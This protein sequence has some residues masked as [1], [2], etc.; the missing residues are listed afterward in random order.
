[1]ARTRLTPR[2]RF[3]SHFRDQDQIPLSLWIFHH[4]ASKLPRAVAWQ[5]RPRDP[6]VREQLAVV[7]VLGI[8]LL[9]FRLRRVKPHH[10]GIFGLIR[11][12]MREA[13]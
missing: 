7:S 1:M 11:G 2:Q 5:I 9:M 4:L 13:T 8:D 3:S 6:H 10:F 12:V